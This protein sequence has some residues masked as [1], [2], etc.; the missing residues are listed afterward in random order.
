MM[1]T[2]AS[3][4]SINGSS[5]WPFHCVMSDAVATIAEI[6]EPITCQGFGDVGFSG[7]SG[8]RL[9]PAK[10]YLWLSIL[11]VIIRALYLSSKHR[12]KPNSFATEP[13]TRQPCFF[14][15]IGSCAPNLCCS[16]MWLGDPERFE[17]PT[18]GLVSRALRNMVPV[19]V[20]GSRPSSRP[21]APY[22][23]R[24]AQLLFA[25]AD[26]Q[27]QSQISE[28]IANSE[29]RRVSLSSIGD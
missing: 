18:S 1:T 17:L 29:G 13:P 12:G 15:T 9:A 23:L 28:R 7:G 10:G 6:T 19:P 20:N 14:L 22:E 27:R 3:A 21:L 8:S 25:G 24:A 16:K 5:L 26:A 11:H 2:M 4:T